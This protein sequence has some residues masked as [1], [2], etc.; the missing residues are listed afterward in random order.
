MSARVMES[1]YYSFWSPSSPLTVLVI[2]NTWTIQESS[3]LAV[4]HLL[5]TCVS[6]WLFLPP[7]FFLSRSLLTLLPHISPSTWHLG[8]GR[9]SSVV[10][11]QWPGC[12]AL[13][14]LAIVCHTLKNENRSR[15]CCWRWRYILELLY[16]VT[17]Y[18]F[19]TLTFLK[20]WL[21]TQGHIDILKG[22]RII[23]CK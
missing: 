4:M 7:A 12:I 19:M 9:I 3:R 2:Q 23:W 22:V 21:K 17:C 14:P 5:P 13:A 20:A 8:A 10:I 11:L 18:Y 15:F 6:G 16:H 1:L